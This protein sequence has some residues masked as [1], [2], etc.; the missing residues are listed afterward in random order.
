LSIDADIADLLWSYDARSVDPEA[1][2]DFVVLAI[3]RLG[4]W[5]QILWAF[6][7]YGLSRVKKVIE[8]DYFGAR[9]LPVSVRAL[10]GHVF[11]PESP[12]PELVN[13]ISRW[14]P[15]RSRQLQERAASEVRRRLGNAL[16]SSGL[17]QRAFASLLGT[18]QPRLSSYLSGK[19]MPSA[20]LLVRAEQVAKALRQVDL[21][22]A[23]AT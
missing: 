6:S 9:S 8:R 20:E 2:A 5:E 3:L 13:P 15:T 10:W 19:V 7:H 23:P 14:Q 22:V 4:T 18:S 21:P 16:S 17:T 1:N 11:W 12:P